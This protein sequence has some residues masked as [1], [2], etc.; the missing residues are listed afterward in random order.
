M[1]V[2][3]YIYSYINIYGY[4][5][6]VTFSISPNR[7]GSKNECLTFA[8]FESAIVVVLLVHCPIIWIHHTHT[9]TNYMYLRALLDKRWYKNQMINL[10]KK[11]QTCS[12]FY[13]NKKKTALKLKLFPSWSR[14]PSHLVKEGMIF[15]KKKKDKGWWG[16]KLKYVNDLKLPTNRRFYTINI[17]VIL[18]WKG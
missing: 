8:P 4:E 6:G 18:W 5:A 16:P 12:S 15:I 2:Y 7:F 11:M 3:I 14:V 17:D 1:C 13:S 9:H 10:I